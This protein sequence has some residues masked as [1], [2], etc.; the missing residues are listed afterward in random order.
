MP[1]L[2]KPC[3]T[4]TVHVCDCLPVLQVW[5]PLKI[6][7]SISLWLVWRSG[8]DARE[9]ALPLSLFGLH[10]FL[11][12]A[13]IGCAVQMALRM[14]PDYMAMLPQGQAW[15][16]CTAAADLGGAV[17][18]AALCCGAANVLLACLL[19]SSQATGGTSCSLASTSL[20]RAPS[21]PE[22]RRRQLGWVGVE[23]TII[24]RSG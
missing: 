6:L 13:P 2:C 3:P 12:E 24:R 1:R 9:L 10:L 18:S 16:S 11:G 8:N 14:G 4:L 23:T 21:E 5:I 19:H 20:R 15:A 17:P 7:Q 22:G